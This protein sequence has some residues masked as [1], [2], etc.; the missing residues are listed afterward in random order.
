MKQ[1]F[2]RTGDEISDDEEV[3][4]RGGELDPKI[5]RA[6]AVRNHQTYGT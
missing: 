3:V 5:L 1:R 6:D 4:V 2:I